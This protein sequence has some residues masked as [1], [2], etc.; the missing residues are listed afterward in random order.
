[1]LIIN[2]NQIHSISQLID[3]VVPCVKSNIVE[4][5]VGVSFATLMIALICK[6]M[7]NGQYNYRILVLYL[8]FLVSTMLYMAERDNCHRVISKPT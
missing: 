1:M 5:I 8:Y 7:K 6:I 2:D 4:I 3:I